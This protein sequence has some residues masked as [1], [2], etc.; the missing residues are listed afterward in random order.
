MR[1]G[2]NVA[3]RGG[4]ALADGTGVGVREVGEGG[5]QGLKGRVGRLREEIVRVLY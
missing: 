2:I 4:L 3:E 1:D 5:A